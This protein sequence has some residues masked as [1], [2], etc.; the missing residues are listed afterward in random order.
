MQLSPFK[1]CLKCYLQ[2][3]KI[4]ITVNAVFSEFKQISYGCKFYPSQHEQTHSA[5]IQIQMQ[6]SPFKQC[7]KC[8][9]QGYKILITVN[10]VFSEFK[11]ISYGCKFYPSQHE[12]THIIVTWYKIVALFFWLSHSYPSLCC[13]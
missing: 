13:K 2:G 1:Q 9:L 4:L 5:E 12:Q 6:L 3:Y 10:A 11:Q 8:Y 7:L